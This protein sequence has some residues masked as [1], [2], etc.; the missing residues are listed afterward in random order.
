MVQRVEAWGNTLEFPDGMSDEDMASAIRKNEANL[1]PNASAFTK[2]KSAVS[3]K[4]DAGL[5]MLT[6]QKS[7]ADQAQ[8]KPTQPANAARIQRSNQIGLR[9]LTS[10]E[11]VP[12]EGGF[13]NSAGRTVGQSIKGAGQ[14]GADYLG[15]SPNNAVKQY[16]QAVI[17]ANPT[18]VNSLEDIAAKPGTA[19]A[20]GTGNAAPSMA[21]MIGA[22]AV[23]QGITALSPLA[24][25]AAPLVA[26][27]GQVVSWLGPAAIAALPSYGG[28]RDKQILND[29][30]AQQSAK[31]K[32]IAAMGAAAVAGIETAF[33]P[34]NWALAAMTK[35][36]RAA[37]AEK[38]ASTTLAGSAGK[39]AVKGGAIEGSEELAQSPIEQLASGDNPTTP[40]S[41]KETAFGT[42]MGTLTGGVLGGGTGML[43]GKPINQ[44][45]DNVLKYTA[46][47]GG[48]KA[49]EAAQAELDRRAKNGIVNNTP[50]TTPEAVQ[51]IIDTGKDKAREINPDAATTSDAIQSSIFDE[52]DK[53]ETPN[54]VT[55]RDE[56]GKVIQ[57]LP[58]DN[59]HSLLPVA[60]DMAGPSGTVEVRPLHDAVAEQGGN[61]TQVALPDNTHLPAQWDVVDADSVSAS[62][63]QGV[64]QPRDRTRAA[65]DVQL[66]GIA[67]NPDYHRL[68]DSPVMDIGSPT[69]SSDGAIVGGNGR[70]EGI[71]RAYDQ[72]TAG[73]YLANLKTDAA[74]KGI[75][76]AKID[77]MKKPVLVRRITQ[78][79]DALT[80]AVASNSGTSLQY[81]GLE[82]A[83][84][85]AERMKG[86]E[87][88]DIT[89][90]GDVALTGSNMQNIR[91]AL[92]GY[93]AAELGALT[94]KD[95]M[96]SQEGMRRIKNSI[97]YQAYGNSP[98]LSRIVESTDND[99]RNISA[100][101]V[102]AA[103]S[104]AKVRS[105]IA[106]GKAPAELDISKDLVASVETLA[107]I[108]SNNQ[109]VDEHLAQSGMFGDD[110]T[111]QEKFIL[112][113]LDTHIRSQKKLTDFIRTYYDSVGKID[114]STSDIFGAETP[115]KQE[116]LKNAKERITDKQPVVQ[117]LF[118]SKPAAKPETS[119]KPDTQSPKQPAGNGSTNESGSKD[120]QVS[121]P[122]SPK[123]EATP[124]AESRKAAEDRWKEIKSKW[125]SSQP[126]KV[127][128]PSTP[129]EIRVEAEKLRA[130]L[131]KGNK[132]YIPPASPKP[133]NPPAPAP[134]A[135]ELPG[136]RPIV[137]SLI[138]RK[139]VAS[140]I[141]RSRSFDTALADAKDL[142][143]GKRV[144]PARFKVIA[145]AMNADKPTAD[146]LMQLYDKALSSHK[147]ALKA[148]KQ[149]A[150]GLSVPEVENHI[151]PLQKAGTKKIKVAASEADLPKNI[152]DAIK[153]AGAAGVRGVYYPQTDEVWL[154][155]D[156]LNNADE[157]IMV[158]LHEAR[159]RG[160]RK[161]FGPE[162]APVMRQI[163]GTNKRVRDAASRMMQ[164]TKGISK[165][166]ATEEV[167][168]D[169]AIDKTAHELNGWKRLVQFVQKWLTDHGIKLKFTDAMVESLVAGA[170]TV[171]TAEDRNVVSDNSPRFSRAGQNS[172]WNSPEP[173]KMD[174]LIYKLQNKHV[175]LKRVIQSIQT[176]GAQLAE[177]WNTYL[178]EE[179][180]H[181]RAAKRTQDFVNRELKPIIMGMKLRGQ[182]V[183]E[184]D[185]YLHARHAEEANKLIAQRDPNMPDGGSG[186]TTQ[187]AKDY[188][189]NLPADKRQALDN[190]AKQVDA[191]I[192]KTRNTYLS[193]GLIDQETADS[194]ENMF[195]HYVPL[196]REDNDGGMGV[197]QGFSIKGKEAKHRTG[198]KRK[199]VD[200]LANIA[201]QRERAI[202]RGEKNRVAV[203]LAGLA[204]LNP[205]PDFW[206]FE[207]VP[208][209]HYNEKTGLVEER[210]DPLYKDRKNVVVAK[211]KDSK[212]RIQEKA[213]IFEESNDR[214]MRM[215]Q[216]MKNLD[217]TQLE[218]L[219]GVSAMIT[220]YFASINT[221]YNPVFGVINLIRDLQASLLNLSSTQIAGHKA[222]VLKNIIPAIG[223]IYS[224]TRGTRKGNLANS[225]M[226]N[227]WDELQN[228]GGMTGYR[229]LFR[230][231]EDRAN[232]IKHELDPTAWMNN[233]LG[234]IFTAGG[235]LKVPLA[236]AQ[237]KAKW[238]FDWLSDYNQTLEG[239]MRLAVYKVAIDNGISKQRAASIG[240]NISVNFNRKGQSGQQAGAL[241]AFFNAAMQ[242][243]ARMGETMTTMEN[244]DP[245]TLKF[246][247]A[248]K[249]II[250]G[251]ISLGVIQALALS[252]AGF[253]DDEPPEFVRERS[254]IIPIGDKKYITIPMPL[255]FHAIPNIGRLSTEFALGGFKKPADY[256]TK[257]FSVFAEAFNPIGNAGMSLQT[258]APTAIDPLAALA[259]NRDWTGKP[260][261]KEDFS[262]LSPTPGFT[263]FK[264][265]ASD[266]AKW[267]AEAINTISGGN[268]YVAG[269]VSP[270]ADQIDYLVGQITG[271]VG[272]E[273]GKAQ[274]SIKAAYTG[275]DLPPHK[276]PLVGRFYGSS[277]NQS[278]QGNAFYSNLK[279]INEVEAELK[280][281]HKDKL[282]LDEFKAEN[283]EY[284]LVNMANIVQ[285]SVSKQRKIKSDLIAHDAPRE[286][287]KA[288]DDRITSLMAGFNGRVK[289]L[290]QIQTA[291][292]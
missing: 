58:A 6:P 236:V 66:Q 20:E 286:Q 135:A 175:D 112:K 180:F 17:D 213:I 64:N 255:G 174:D 197:G 273:A 47:R 86:L 267:I 226:A 70:F 257:L 72:G 222:E 232:A 21:G 74:A 55:A 280:G 152:Q 146:I 106:A 205:N 118:A 208:K 233:G 212:G 140:Q 13:L 203:S 93:N 234:K 123:K 288:I 92:S 159:H 107:K 108:R 184:L 193:Y 79:F 220:R 46:E 284:R 8:T 133:E 75:D 264:D 210:A 141:G 4:V 160:L 230:T 168:A 40:E 117:D 237:K 95:G 148:A 167:L 253:D 110:L 185:K 113:T 63:K 96:L 269:T 150:K 1:N 166:E 277:E 115:S 39:G 131:T 103:G 132:E 69:L 186:M 37:L 179:L 258:I 276:I 77:G 129:L 52:G 41:L 194:W 25:P 162:V 217:A 219:F 49:K 178:Q 187:D 136:I 225:P 250:A 81:S 121:P 244:G 201:L 161:L 83:K 94:D 270:T 209:R 285:R 56:N 82:L 196:M 157:A 218:G 235:T 5:S 183:D 177:Q 53:P 204:K 138:K 189:A 9:A 36:G 147:A 289:E 14:I 35:Q 32:A 243:T 173:S 202:V 26:A 134:K 3:S 188:L 19:I 114:L 84:I 153:S 51:R 65:S 263:R 248:G 127:W 275:E 15:A 181:G 265:T 278:S 256:T 45:P 249:T 145:D 78:P 18:A 139:A 156:K 62:L 144:K 33:G 143:A 109:S 101:L 242:G 60:K 158:A 68:S 279:R 30:A 287:V 171:G 61:A 89:D 43:L 50:E 207:N 282:P 261:Y 176:T 128:K 11:P 260:I 247:K 221:Q 34:Q 125:G 268:K 251:G 224:S 22:R 88:L 120:K 254:L 44:V 169:M 105:D 155:A 216:A 97:L 102:K 238:I 215:A 252:A 42:V 164:S 57:D 119:S 73:N 240:K 76:P 198:S 272:R 231:S 31:S 200:I 195:K 16:G 126:G 59:N 165:E 98:T 85:D 290:K 130:I 283:P 259:E 67:N 38:F 111:E 199:V 271:G 291:A 10:A 71:S 99:M 206:T 241:Y 182:T 172:S 87:H 90:S 170:E 27:A 116:L 124:A 292:Q 223:A 246:N 191:V 80:L 154:V 227:L 211:I 190:T 23:G 149:E 274:Q 281:R 48:K 100:A 28:I 214:A 266:P 54:V 12:E 163:Y 239:A 245:K 228:E 262:K 142:M 24:G 104:V 2:A 91:H 192:A 7:I 122:V 29:P 151:A 229:D 137:E